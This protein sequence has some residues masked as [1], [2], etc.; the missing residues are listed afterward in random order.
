MTNQEKQQFIKLIEAGML[1]I[2]KGIDGDYVIFQGKIIKV[3]STVPSHEH[4][5]SI[6][7]SRTYYF[8]I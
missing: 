1:S 2:I 8:E 5:L 7:D 4:S 3:T 6:S